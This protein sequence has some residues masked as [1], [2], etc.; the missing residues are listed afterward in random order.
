[1]I[2]IGGKILESTI[3]ETRVAIYAKVLQQLRRPNYR[4]AMEVDSRHLLV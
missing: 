3:G 4:L 2:K 1:M